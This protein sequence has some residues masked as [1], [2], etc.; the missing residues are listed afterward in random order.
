M[1]S[2][3]PVTVRSFDFATLEW[4]EVTVDAPAPP[5]ARGRR[6]RKPGQAARRGA[7][8]DMSGLSAGSPLPTWWR[9]TAYAP[10][11]PLA[12]MRRHIPDTAMKTHRAPTVAFTVPG[13]G[14]GTRWFDL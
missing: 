8:R 10:G 14:D 13:T 7:P 5:R 6:T 3:L 11:E 4:H 9:D 12:D 1:P 2:T